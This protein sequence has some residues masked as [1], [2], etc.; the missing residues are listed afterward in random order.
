MRQSILSLVTRALMLGV[1]REARTRL[2][3]L[4][5]LSALGRRGRAIEEW[6]ASDDMT[7]G[8]GGCTCRVSCDVLNHYF[9]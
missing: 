1:V 5:A 6:D 2:L 3:L 8:G 7:T 9:C 4:R